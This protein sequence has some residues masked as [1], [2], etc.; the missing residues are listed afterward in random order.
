MLRTVAIIPA[1][2]A[3]TRLENKPLADLEGEPLIARVY[4]N[5]TRIKSVY[6]VI[7][8][9]DSE[10]VAAAASAAGAEVVMTPASLPSGSD[11]VYY[12][13]RAAAADADLIIN[14]QGD[15]PFLNTQA[16][17]S[18]VEEANTGVY[19]DVFSLYHRISPEAAAD[20]QKVKVVVDRAGH[21][22][23]F[24]RSPIPYAAPEYLKH[25][26]VYLWRK[27]ALEIFNFLEPSPLEKIERLEQMR[28]VE[29][30]MKIRMR[31]SS[32][33]SP[34]IDTPEDLEEARRM[35]NA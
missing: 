31:E 35:L 4:K 11:R 16:V 27:N 10:E 15:E 13:A 30:G 3:S 33:D 7:V 23:C 32:S 12:A 2:L 8:A 14:V 18:L 20:P 26:G 19:A 17:D 28:A 9:V 5:A 22:I 25:I 21:A 24:S 1:R 34:G 29:N 6:K